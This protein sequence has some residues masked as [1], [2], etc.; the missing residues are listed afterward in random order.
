MKD[1]CLVHTAC[2]EVS[3]YY[4]DNG[5][6]DW[7]DDHYKHNFNK[8]GICTCNPTVRRNYFDAR[9]KVVIHNVI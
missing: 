3:H 2:R 5:D 8:E 4:T 1:F 9:I 6:T 7:G